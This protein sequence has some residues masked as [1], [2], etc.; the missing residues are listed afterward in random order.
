MWLRCI[1]KGHVT[2]TRISLRLGASCWWKAHRSACEV[3]RWWWCCCL[4]TFNR[5]SGQKWI[6]WPEHEKLWNFT[7]WK[8]YIF[9]G[10]PKQTVLQISTA[11]KEMQECMVPSTNCHKFP[12]SEVARS[13][14]LSCPFPNEIQSCVTN[15]FKTAHNIYNIESEY[16]MMTAK[17]Y[18]YL[19]TYI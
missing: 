10:E 1:W 12:W 9:F 3:L 14:T 7:D 8:I 13:P 19:I 18:V 15:T 4:R 5:M 11:M 6:I 2:V 16:L 17:V